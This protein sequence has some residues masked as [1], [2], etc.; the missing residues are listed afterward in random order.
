MTHTGREFLE[1][2]PSCVEPI[3]INIGYYKMWVLR[4][5]THA[6]LSV[7]ILDICIVYVL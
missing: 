1:K 3:A 7:F 2:N 6:C 5:Y 4:T